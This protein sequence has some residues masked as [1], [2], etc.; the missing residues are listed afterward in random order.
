[1][2]EDLDRYKRQLEREQRDLAEAKAQIRIHKE[3]L[4]ADFGVDNTKAA[5]RKLQ[6]LKEQRT[7]QEKK[8]KKKMNQFK[9][10]WD[11]LNEH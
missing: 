3:E 1:M 6:K 9:K 4:K 8:R 5:R 2:K 10:K 7:K 11:G